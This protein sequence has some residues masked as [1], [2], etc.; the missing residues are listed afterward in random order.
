MASIDGETCFSVRG[1]PPDPMIG[2][3]TWQI[4]PRPGMGWVALGERP[5]PFALVTVFIGTNDEV[6]A[7]IVHIEGITDPA[8]NGPAITIVNNFGDSFEQ[9][10]VVRVGSPN[11]KAVKFLNDEGALTAGS[12]C[13]MRIEGWKRQENA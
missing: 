7:W 10:L 8:G 9:C 13:E 12:R 2:I 1:H 6:A 3:K 11:R 5:A 4:P